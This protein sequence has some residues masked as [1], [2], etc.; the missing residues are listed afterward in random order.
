[1][2]FSSKS[3]YKKWLSYVHA[4]KLA[5]NT[6]G[7]Q[8]VSIKGKSHSVKHS[9]GGLTKAELNLTK[10]FESL[11]NTGNDVFPQSKPDGG[12]IVPTS[13]ISKESTNIV[14]VVTLSLDENKLAVDQAD[15]ERMSFI[16]DNL[17]SH[18]LYQKVVNGADSE[19]LNPG[20]RKV[21]NL[22]HEKEYGGIARKQMQ[23]NMANTAQGFGIASGIAGAIPG[24]GQLLSPLIGLWGNSVKEQQ[25]EAM[26]MKPIKQS[27]NIYGN[28]KDG[29]FVNNNF[30]QYDSGSH[31]SGM[32]QGIDVNGNPS[33]KADG[34]YIQNKEN[35]YSFDDN[36]YVM[37]DTLVN[38]ET[39]NYFNQD[40]AKL[41][42]Q[43]KQASNIP[44]DENSLNFGM[45]RLSTLNDAMRN[46]KEG[47]LKACGGST[48]K[49]ASG[50]PTDDPRFKYTVNTDTTPLETFND[51]LP[52]SQNQFNINI[53]TFSLL[54]KD[55]ATDN[56]QLLSNNAVNLGQDLSKTASRSSESGAS[57]PS[58]KQK[59]EPNYNWIA[60]GLKG[61]ALAKS[62]SD[63]LTPAEEE[64]VI[65]PD[66]TKADK[67][68]Y[69]ANIDY[70]QARQ[71][72]MAASNLASNVNRSSSSGFATYQGRQSANF[73]NLSDQLG[74]IAMQENNQRSQLNMQR[75]QY[76]AN[77]S[78]DVANRQY[79]NRIDNMMNKANADLAD[80]KLFSELSQ[81]GTTFN[82]YQYYKDALKNNKEL[83]QMKIKEASAI[84]SNKYESFG[85][86]EDFI[87]KI[88]EG[89]YEDLDFNEVIKFIAT[90]DQI[91]KSEKK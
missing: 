78:I 49:M 88:S 51:N 6:P 20:F 37:S 35:A 40:A 42:K 63:A 36:T 34:G 15:R 3:N 2:N 61:V 7:N 60:A 71:N 58:T 76:E 52:Y 33:N 67:Q 45:K 80:Q 86:N 4:N 11:F 69:S 30:K 17:Q 84:L 81:I 9:M 32:D 41:N 68:I 82:D 64:T 66:Y 39:G 48:K 59:K 56:T 79:Q 50:G 27:S 89:D 18:L 57:T 38:P 83:A 87:K 47:V 29:G 26:N 16:N 62:I 1:M 12:P 53:P 72:A 10:A 75:G 55:M 85:F 90:A 70:T 91:K 23:E 73:A 31:D 65:T 25:Q 22:Y 8:S 54:P 14:P 5:E 28:F 13:L 21:K 43:H 74:N 19:K 24:V 44:E 77:K 46:I